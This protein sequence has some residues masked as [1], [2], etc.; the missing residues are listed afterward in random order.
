MSINSKRDLEMTFGNFPFIDL[1]K[2][3]AIRKEA[4]TSNTE[5][6]SNLPS[7]YRNGKTDGLNTKNETSRAN[8]GN[9]DNR[10]G[11]EIRKNVQE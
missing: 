10:M 5:A 7:S 9:E 11:Q 1:E 2:S 4:H 6:E 8:A 3:G